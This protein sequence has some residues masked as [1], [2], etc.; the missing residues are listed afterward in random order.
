MAIRDI[1][2]KQDEGFISLHDLLMKMTAVHGDTLQDAATL[3]LRLLNQADNFERPAWYSNSLDK[4]VSLVGQSREVM[5]ALQYV[6]VNGQWD[7]DDI[8]F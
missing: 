4:G 8:P 3:L 6:A 2:Q 5:F 7:S 1:L